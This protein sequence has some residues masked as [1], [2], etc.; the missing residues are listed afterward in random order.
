MLLSV[1]FMPTLQPVPQQAH[2]IS[3]TYRWQA[4]SHTQL[5]P[6]TGTP[7]PALYPQS[8]RQRNVTLG[9]LHAHLI[10]SRH[11]PGLI[12]FQHTNCTQTLPSL[13]QTKQK[14]RHF[15]V[16]LYGG[17][18][19]IRTTEAKRNRFTVCPLWPLGN[20]PIFT[21]SALC[22]FLIADCL[23]IIAGIFQKCNPFFKIFLKNFRFFSFHWF[24]PLL[25]AAC[26]RICRP[27]S[28]A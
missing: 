4:P 9:K 17:S 22:F 13:F 12:L 24:R 16:Y 5:T 11:V 7:L 25:Y 28:P 2:V 19:W 6:A 8:P 26:E 27:S 10:P 18:G 3:A 20:T 14:G 21:C 15:H 1:S 23:F